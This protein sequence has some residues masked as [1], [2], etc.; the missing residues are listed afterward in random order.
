MQY[1]SFKVE[2]FSQ[3]NFEE[4]KKHTK[5]YKYRAH[6]TLLSKNFSLFKVTEI[7]RIEEDDIIDLSANFVVTSYPFESN[8]ESKW[9]DALTFRPSQF[10]EL[11]G[12]A[13]EASIREA[14]S[15]CKYN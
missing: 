12:G 8:K 13:I 9:K 14:I 1:Q 11:L 3:Q 6:I 4:Q 15:T 10:F 2:F 7:Q 5:L